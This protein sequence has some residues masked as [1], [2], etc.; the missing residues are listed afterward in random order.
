MNVSFSGDWCIEFADLMDSVA[1]V[2]ELGGSSAAQSVVLDGRELGRWDS[3]FM[4]FL[5]DFEQGCAAHQASLDV[6]GMPSG[7]RSLLDLASAV[8]E[9]EGARRT[10]SRIAW[11]AEVGETA[12]KLWE[13]GLFLTRFLSGLLVVLDDPSKFISQ[14]FTHLEAFYMSGV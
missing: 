6:S 1:V 9:R 5:L 14:F 12:R 2:T 7:V 4:T 8:P 11:L 10:V 13:D 3:A